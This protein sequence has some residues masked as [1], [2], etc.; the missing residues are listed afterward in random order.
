VIVRGWQRLSTRPGGTVAGLATAI[1]AD[2]A[3]R[4]FAATSAGV[5]R[6]ADDG[7]TWTATSV[8]DVVPFNETVAPSPDFARDR[9]LFAGGRTGLYRSV[10]EGATWLRVLAGG[11]ISSLALAPGVLFAGTE[12]DGVLRSEDRGRT[13]TSANPGL[14]DLSVLALALSPAFG[15]DGIGFAATP[16]ALYRTRNGGKSWRAVELDGDEPGVQCLALSPGFAED[17]LVLAGTESDGLFRSDD[18]GGRWEPVA[19]LGGRSVTALAFSSGSTAGQTIAAATDLGIFLSADGGRSWRI[20]AADLGPVL[21]LVF[22]PHGA[23]ES[24]LAGLHRDGV[25]RAASGQRAAWA[26][27]NDGLHARLPVGLTISPAFEEDQTLFAAGPDDGVLV[28]T[29]GGHTWAAQLVGPDDPSVSCVAASPDYARDR[30]LYAATATGVHRSRDGGATWQATGS[31]SDAARL[32]V[33]GPRSVLA[34]MANGAV[35]ESDDHG[36]T[37]RSLGEGFAGTQIVSLG[38]SP[39]YP[40]DRTIFVGSSAAAGEVVLWR[41]SDGGSRWGRWLVERGGELLPLA[42]P[43]TYPADEVVFVGLGGRLLKPVQHAREVRAGERRPIWR[44]VDV[45]GSVTAL[46]TPLDA[47]GGGT[48]FVGTSGGVYVSRDAG[49]NLTAW[50]DGPDPGPHAVVALAVSPG[51]ARDR[52]VFALELGGALWRRRDAE[53]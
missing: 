7:R 41:S 28:S 53:R 48:V 27:A 21:T 45:G 19:G 22:V 23:A 25:A 40:R 30:T 50:I 44:G 15:R 16:S 10:D 26:H 38:V 39:D 12:Q 13:W 37:W 9:T 32:V 46:A 33:A 34:A 14:L 11:R 24:L 35:L 31:E 49:E 47:R 17:R 1:A 3:T 20:S 5:F 4:V 42:V 2:G 29:D 36:E 52:L 18:A 51:Y 6:S 43:A 8:A